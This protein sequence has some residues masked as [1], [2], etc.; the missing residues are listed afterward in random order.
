MFP[1]P[2]KFGVRVYETSPWMLVHIHINAYIYVSMC[3]F[4]CVPLIQTGKPVLA[5]LVPFRSSLEI[6]LV[7]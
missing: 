4:M 3:M 6:V 5:V 1:Y 2:P 7:M